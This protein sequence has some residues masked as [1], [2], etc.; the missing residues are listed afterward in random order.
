MKLTT[1]FATLALAAATALSPA[2]AEEI[3]VKHAQG[4]TTLPDTPKKVLVFDMASLDTLDALGVEVTGVPGGSKPE[5]LKKYEGDQYLKIGTLFE[6]D[7]E[8][9]NAAEP[10]LII[11]GGRSAPK[12]AELSKIAPTI[13]MTVAPDHFLDH[14]RA[15]VETLAKIFGKEE[16]AKE[17]LAKLDESIA[18][19]K[20]K[21][22]NA[23]RVLT[24]LTTGG[25]ISAHGRGGRFTILYDDFGMTPAAE[26]LDVGTHGQSISNEFILEN[27]PD[28][29]LVVDRDAAIGQQGEAAQ[30]VLDNDLVRQTNAWKNGHVVYLN[31]G[32]WYIIGAGLNA[33]QSDVDELLAAFSK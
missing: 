10:D 22:A 6:P 2:M 20:E 3:T 18:A 28:W 1:I 13:D 9:V 19:L 29:L 8:A 31:P 23:G 30:Q 24:I 25:R 4:E 26:G 12:Y 7:Y 33:V 21:T 17:K 15:N 5:T 14:M 27:N 11:V 16:L 32:N